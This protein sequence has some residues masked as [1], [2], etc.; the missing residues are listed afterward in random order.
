MNISRLQIP[1]TE[2]QPIHAIINR[3]RRQILL[4]SVLYYTFDS[5]LIQDAK[6]DRWAHELTVLQAAFPGDASE[7]EFHDHF[8]H[9]SGTSG[10][11]LP[12]KRPDVVARALSMKRSIDRCREAGS[13]RRSD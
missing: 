1:D 13:A 3:R 10:F 4:H 11:D 9:F 6:F 8:R 12:L 5:P 7:C 2:E